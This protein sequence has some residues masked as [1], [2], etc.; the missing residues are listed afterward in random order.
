MLT[1]CFRYSHFLV[2]VLSSLVLIVLSITGIV[3]AIEPIEHQVIYHD[4]NSEGVTLAEVM[5]HLS[6]YEVYEIRVDEYNHTIASLYSENLEGDY[7]INPC[8][9]AVIGKVPRRSELYS[10]CTKIHRSLL[11]KSTGRGIVG[12]TAFLLLVM[13]LSGIGL[14]IQKQQSIR[15]FFGKIHNSGPNSYLHTYFGRYF[16]IPIVLIGVTGLS[17]SLDRFGFIATSDFDRKIPYLDQKAL[18][19]TTLISDVSSLEYPLSSDEDEYYILNQNGLQYSIHQHTHELIS[20]DIGAEHHP[21]LVLAKDLHTGRSNVFIAFILLI[22]SF[23]ILYFIYSGFMISFVRLSSNTKN[24]IHPSDARCIVLFGSENGITKKIARHFFKTIKNKYP[25]VYFCSL[26]SFRVFHSAEHLIIF[27]STYGDGAPP[28]NAHRFLHKLRAARPKKKVSYSIVGFGSKSYPKF[29]QFAKDIHLDMQKHPLY[30]ELL[31]PLYIHNN[32]MQQL[33]NWSYQWSQATHIKGLLLKAPKLHSPKLRKFK[34]IDKTSVTSQHE[35][36]FTLLISPLR[37]TNFQDGDLLSVFP[38]SDN[39][40]RQYSIGKTGQG[41]IILSIKRHDFGL[42]SQ[43]LYKLEK[44]DLIKC[45]IEK[46]PRF[47]MPK[48]RN[49]IF[50]ANGTG[51]APFLGMI[52]NGKGMKH[53]FWGGRSYA[54]WGLYQERVEE[55][56]KSGRLQS[57]YQAY[58]RED[59]P[60]Y[61]QDIIYEKSLLIIERIRGGATIM[62]CGSI[63]MKNGVCETL[64]TIFQQ[65]NMN[66]CQ[67]LEKQGRLL[68]DCY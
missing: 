15:R 47:Y 12:I 46:N 38:K 32:N 57:V 45:C 2:A 19:K 48:N 29:C 36:I 40:K 10:L 60:K 7:Y 54:S 11:L 58:S 61:V 27:T 59:D 24:H 66:T 26:N 17:L 53:M 67:I 55:A 13:A 5:S 14:V 3:L 18:L 41:Q 35:T 34:V 20:W 6:G 33:K 4:S 37:H 8:N 30:Y 52:N 23:A 28:S 25:S 63:T 50:I 1:F 49:V 22:S 62:I 64:D 42:C 44:G 56:L 39:V 9:G 65:R 31:P 68:T 51:I 21:M 16:L 43:Q